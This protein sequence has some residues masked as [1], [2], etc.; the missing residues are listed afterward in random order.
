MASGVC[1]VTGPRPLEL[2][3]E[4]GA[5]DGVER[6]IVDLQMVSLLDPWAQ[7]FLGGETGR[8]P[9]GPLNRG[10]HMRRE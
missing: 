7:R 3:V 2:R 9:E 10:Q 4:P 1:C 5:D 6:V 8:W